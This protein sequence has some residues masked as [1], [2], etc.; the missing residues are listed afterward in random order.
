MARVLDTIIMI[1]MRDVAIKRKNV[2]QFVNGVI[3]V[4][5]VHAI[6]IVSRVY[7]FN[8]ELIMRMKEMVEFALFIEN[9]N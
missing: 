6:P 1:M 9:L 7:G 2:P 8:D 4:N 3:G 5:G